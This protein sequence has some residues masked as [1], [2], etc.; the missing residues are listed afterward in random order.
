MSYAIRLF[1][2]H[3]EFPWCAWNVVLSLFGAEE[4]KDFSYPRWVISTED[5]AVWLWL[6]QI[7]LPDRW[8]Y[9]SKYNWVIEI[10]SG[11]CSHQMWT[12]YALAIYTLASIEEVVVE[13]DWGTTIEFTEAEKLAEYAEKIL[14]KY[15]RIQDLCQ[16][17]LLKD[18]KVVF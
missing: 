10:D 1:F 7:D 4:R 9:S 11:S 18:G 12:Q 15:A 17:G 3:K 2:P 13:Q 5:V 6:R 14:K 8:A 16:L